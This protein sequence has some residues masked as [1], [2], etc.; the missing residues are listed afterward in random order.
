MGLGTFYG[1]V[2][3]SR[4]TKSHILLLLGGRRSVNFSWQKPGLWTIGSRPISTSQSSL[5]V[6]EEIQQ[7]P[8]NRSLSARM[9]FIFDQMDKIEKEKSG[10]DEALQQIRAWRERKNLLKASVG[11][12]QM[13]SEETADMTEKKLDSEEREILGFEE[14]ET[15]KD[16]FSQVEVEVVHP[17]PEWIELMERLL[18]QNY[19]E[20]R[21]K[22]EDDMLEKFADVSVTELGLNDES[23]V[24]TRD[25]T[26]VRTAVLNFGR[27]RFDILRS[28]SRKDIQVLVGH[29]CPSVD[30]K[31][32]F[33]GKVLRK[34]VHLDEGDV[35]SSCSLRSSCDRAYLATCKEDDARTLDVMRVLLTYGFEPITGSVEN[36]ALLK[37]KS[38][39]TVVRK[40][41]HEVVKLS[42]VPI[43]PNLPPPVIKKPPPKIKQPPPPPKKRVGRDDIEMKKGDWLCPKCDFMNFA[44][45]TVCLQCDARRP[46]RQ[47]LPG[48]WECPG[49]NFLNYRRNMTCFHCDH[50]RPPE[51]EIDNPM[52]T[53]PQTPRTR[54]E[55]VASGKNVSNAWNFDFD[56]DESDGADVAA[57]EFADPPNTGENSSVNGKGFDDQPFEKTPFHRVQEKGRYF[58][59]DRREPSSASPR[60]GFDDFDDE[61]DVDDYELDT[62]NT[63]DLPSRKLESDDYDD[64]TD[65]EREIASHSFHKPS[66]QLRGRPGHGSSEDDD[67][68]SSDSDDDEFDQKSNRN[69]GLRQGLRVRG[70]GSPHRSMSF[71]SE[72]EGTLDSDSDDDLGRG[73]RSRF[74]NRKTPNLNRK[75]N[76]RSYSDS[77]DDVNLGPDSE[78]EGDWISPRRGEREKKGGLGRRGR[79]SYGNFND[80]KSPRNGHF[81]SD[82]MRGNERNSF[83]TNRRPDRRFGG[84]R[85][86]GNEMSFKSRGSEKD[87]RKDRGLGRGSRGDDFGG[88]RMNDRKGT[89]RDFDAA[90]QGGRGRIQRR[91]RFGGLD[92]HQNGGSGEERRRVR[93]IER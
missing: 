1:L 40:L 63:N 73:S 54:L 38:I 61:D 3:S 17:W 13:G 77:E 20:Y 90:S 45:N 21:R 91:E 48:E 57:F 9:S 6:Q 70:R 49:C 46:K 28:L 44:K 16:G 24:F 15:K 25:W 36:K 78:D 82:G 67:E 52:P 18:Q 72:D 2:P 32:V 55:R 14:R 71:D 86:S 5:Q 23:F 58:S 35:C 93:V 30:T 89:F 59:R 37:M 53:N 69:L 43:D 12:S 29:G 68:Q 27:D 51:A 33:S 87:F 65:D 84:S 60:T 74:K 42:A 83:G 7:F 39:K 62:S 88:R 80:H 79:A 56:D 11:V 92:D 81:R 8:E 4:N 34:Y 26:T 75:G 19:F 66:R 85:E 50:K 31:V 76:R 64:L 10:K 22:N 47:L 41:L